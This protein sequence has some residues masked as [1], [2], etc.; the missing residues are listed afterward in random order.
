[1]YWLTSDLC[2]RQKYILISGRGVVQW[3]IDW[4]WK[5]RKWFIYSQLSWYCRRG[6]N[7]E[8]KKNVFLHISILFVILDFNDG[9]DEGLSWTI[10]V[11]VGETW[12][13]IQSS[14]LERTITDDVFKAN[15]VLCSLSQTEHDIIL[16]RKT[17]SLTKDT[18]I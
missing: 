17:R 13:D 9:W 14:Y 18:R 7:L 11:R 16:R 12:T 6:N 4:I 5:E 15:I 3:C 8:A 2:C 1:M 10:I